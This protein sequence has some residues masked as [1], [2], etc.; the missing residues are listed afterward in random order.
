MKISKKQIEAA[1]AILGETD[2]ANKAGKVRS[3]LRSILKD[4]LEC[5]RELFCC[6]KSQGKKVSG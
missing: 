2:A 1:V 4:I 6:E 3:A 5:V